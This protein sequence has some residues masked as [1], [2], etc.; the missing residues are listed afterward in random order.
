MDEDLLDDRP[1]LAADLDRQRAA[2]EPGLDGGATD[3]VAPVARDAPVGTFELGLARL[4]DVADER[5]RPRLE[6][7]LGGAEGQVHRRQGCPTRRCVSGA[8]RGPQD[9]LRAA[10]MQPPIPMGRRYPVI[11]SV[12]PMAAYPIC[13]VS[14][15]RKHLPRMDTLSRGLDLYTEPNHETSPRRDLRRTA[16][17]RG[18][19]GLAASLNLTSDSL[20]AGHRGR[21]SLPGRHAE[22]DLHLD[23]FRGGARL[24]GRHRHRHRARCHLLQQGLQDHALRRRQCL[25]R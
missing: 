12:R 2:V 3:R 9:D 6:L 22:R 15:P 18:R 13:T 16:Y 20:G 21:R 4:E 19:L 8:R 14:Y 23:L 10:G 1:A 7:E 24:H 17:L 5:P 25:A 11:W